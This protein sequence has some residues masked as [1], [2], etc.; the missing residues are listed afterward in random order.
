V[1]KVLERLL[2][3]IKDKE[4]GKKAIKILVSEKA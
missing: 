3:V 1:E 4:I 2:V